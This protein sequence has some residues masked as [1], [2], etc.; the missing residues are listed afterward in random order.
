MKVLIRAARPGDAPSIAR[1]TN[2][3]ILHTTVHFGVDPWPEEE[4][5]AARAS[6]VEQGYP[7]LVAHDRAGEIQ[8]YAKAG[9]W[10]ARPAYR[11]T[12]E[13]GLYVEAGM[14]RRGIGRALYA[15][16]IEALE[17]GEFRTA[18][19]GVT[20]PNPASEALHLA[21]GF[22]RVGTFREVGFKDGRWLDVAWF[23][24]RL[25]EGPSPGP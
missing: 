21:A 23:L 20:L 15:A 18:V 7:W 2:H 4:V 10:R 19:A 11:F 25:G 24:R 22:E 13:T 1:I 8:G 3:Y 17:Q 12:T 6:G 9:R 14:R 5:E 16:L